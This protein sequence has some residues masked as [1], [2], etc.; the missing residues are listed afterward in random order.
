[1][2]TENPLLSEW[3]T[4]YGLPPFAA[5]RAEHFIPAFEVALQ[6][7]ITEVE[8]IAANPEAATFDNTVAAF[9]ASGRLL[10][11]ISH[12][13]H[14]LCSSETSPALQAVERT[15]AP[16][17]AAHQNAIYLNAALFAR[18]DSLHACR[19]GL[20]LAPEAR[21]LLERVHLDFV[22]AGARLDERAKLRFA[23]VSER[24]AELQTTFSQNVL[25]DESTWVL[26]LADERDLAGLPTFVRAA[27]REAAEQRGRSDAWAITLSR[28]LVAPFLT[29]SD[30]RDLREHAFKAWTQRGEH[31]GEHDNRPVA[32]EILALRH[33]QARLMG[34]ASYAEYALVD[35]MAGTPAAVARLL[36]QV[37]TPAKKRAAEERDALAALAASRGE[38]ITIEPWDWRYYA[39]KVRQVRYAVDDAAVKPYF[40]LERVVA[41]AFDCAGRLF[42]L[43]FM[44]CPEI[45]AY[46]P[47]VKVYEVRG[48]DGRQVGVFLHDNFAR[49]T[50]R[51]GAWM[52]SYRLQSRIAGDVL[53]IIVNNN[54]FAKGAPGEP[55][56]LSLDDALTLFHEFGHGLHGLLSQ[57]TF[58][59]LSGTQVL[60]DF[61]E[62]PSQ[63]FENWL[64]EPEVLKKHARHVETGQPMPDELI[65][66]L[67][68]ARRFNQGF[69]TV[70]YTAC[71]LVDMALHA[72]DN[73]A[74][75]D[76]S[77]FEREELARIG[78]PREIVM[79][80]RL[81]HFL[82]LFASSGY[83]AGYYVYMWA[84]VLDAD[85][86][87]AFLEA[88]NPFDPAVAERLRQYVY[89]AGNTLE[90]GEA[91]RAF[92]G[93]DPKVEP[94]LTKRGLA[95]TV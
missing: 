75:V 5:V 69:E 88:G 90:P 25:H 61:V 86:Y 13:F 47:D 24:L 80:H 62:L 41:A 58:E 44:P 63:I 40:A 65:A 8:Q 84:E 43:R 6:R 94:M 70:E 93:R 32:R 59:S 37:W 39:E 4:P 74:G 82:H 54:N 16:R 64:L 28:S 23:A 85:G 73:S 42:G 7:H 92:R 38:T 14:N 18:I 29:Y 30:R 55:T 34:Y 48:R 52:S 71:A 89:S 68:Q 11:R 83:A 15:M 19:D 78:M 53:P 87:D 22:L 33:E 9:D 35:R 79:R 17:L 27:A 1:M 49:P 21:R 36:E 50:K 60:R 76:I 20:G 46:H 72:R 45:T 26:W 3:K 31:A 10:A 91:F 2:T 12:L 56:L 67:E 77:A 57:V 81:P 51:G 66:R 95:A